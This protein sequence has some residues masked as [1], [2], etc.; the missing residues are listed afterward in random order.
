VI[1]DTLRNEKALMNYLGFAERGEAAT[2]TTTTAVHGATSL[3][4]RE[5]N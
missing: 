3:M 1:D 2:E 5:G 4:N